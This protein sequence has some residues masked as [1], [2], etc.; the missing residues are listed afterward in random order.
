MVA[1]TK[2]VEVLFRSEEQDRMSSGMS[3]S[4]AART[5]WRWDY[6]GRR[7]LRLELGGLEEN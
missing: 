2:H 1:E 5:F 7:T 3:T 6:P 4:V